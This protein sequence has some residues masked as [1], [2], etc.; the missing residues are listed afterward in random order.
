MW[1]NK[2]RTMGMRRRHVELVEGS[3]VALY[4]PVMKNDTYGKGTE[5]VLAWRTASGV[6]IGEYVKRLSRRLDASQIPLDGPFFCASGPGACSFR[7]P[8]VGKE[9]RFGGVLLLHLAQV[10]E[11]FAPG[12]VLRTRFSWHSL[13]RGGASYAFRLGLDM[14]LIM[15][16]GAWRTEGGIAPYVAAGLRGKLSVTGAM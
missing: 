5:V 11:E 15:G 8:W 14:R 12:S 3:H 1:L 4:L 9:S 16:H 13:R 6:P 7:E 2:L 10:Y